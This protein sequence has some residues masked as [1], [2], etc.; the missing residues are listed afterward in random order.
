[1]E[2]KDTLKEIDIKNCICYYFDDILRLTNFGY[3][4]ILLDEKSYENI[5]IYNI[6]CK[7]FMGSKPLRIWFETIDGFIKIYDGI[8]YLVLFDPKSYDAIYNRIKYLISK[9]SGITDI[10]NH[11]FTRIRID[12]LS[13]LLIRTK[14][15]T[16]IIYF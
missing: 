6:S 10:I 12:S 16:T 5:L 2:S 9:K 14:I 13:Q 8:R 7:N 4:N 11:D 15:T 1:M 3:N